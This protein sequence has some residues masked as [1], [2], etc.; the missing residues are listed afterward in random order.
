MLVA[1]AAAKGVNCD[2][3]GHVARHIKPCIKHD[4]G[5]LV[6][7]QLLQALSLEGEP[8]LTPGMSR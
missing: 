3:K 6:M 5:P 2:A 7:L 1:L 4:Q 8:T